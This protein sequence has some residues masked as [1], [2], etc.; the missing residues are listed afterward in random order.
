MSGCFFIPSLYKHQSM[1]LRKKIRIILLSSGVSAA[2][3][4]ENSLKPFQRY[5]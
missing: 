3:C 1:L 2:T 4:E 5:I